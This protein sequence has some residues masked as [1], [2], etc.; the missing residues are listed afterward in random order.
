VFIANDETIRGFDSLRVRQLQWWQNGK[1]DA[2]YKL[3]GS[4][5]YTVLAPGAIVQT[6]TLSS[7]RSVQGV[8]HE[9][10]LSVTD[11][12]RETSAGWRV[13]YAHESIVVH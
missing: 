13:V 6:Y 12:W 11:I 8:A 3:V 2:V 4:P 5:E 7:P 9:A 1:S 10:R